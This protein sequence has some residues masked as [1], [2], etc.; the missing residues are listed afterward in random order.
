MQAEHGKAVKKRC[1][2]EEAYSKHGNC[3][4]GKVITIKLKVAEGK[5]DIKCEEETEVPPESMKNS[6]DNDGVEIDVIDN[7]LNFS[8]SSINKMK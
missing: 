8:S 3:I 6:N 2:K 4:K 7:L 1:H 5:E